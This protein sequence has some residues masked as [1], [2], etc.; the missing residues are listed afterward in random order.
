MDLYKF[1]FEVNSKSDVHDS[2]ALHA[3]ER[4]FITWSMSTEIMTFYFVA[5]ITLRTS[6]YIKI[7]TRDSMDLYIFAFEVS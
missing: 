5:K 2:S 4:K 6:I 1:A 7:T 3:Y